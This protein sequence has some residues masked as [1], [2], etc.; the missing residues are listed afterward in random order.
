MVIIKECT[1][2]EYFVKI[3]NYG[4]SIKN[5][6]AFKDNFYGEKALIFK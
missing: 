2:Y 1:A 4:I 5:P 6:K 3:K